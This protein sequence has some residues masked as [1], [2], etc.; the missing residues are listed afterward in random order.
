VREETSAHILCECE[1]LASL[2]HANLGSFFLKPEAI[3]ILVLGAIWKFNEVTG[4]PRFDVAHKG[5]IV[6]AY[7]HRGCEVPN[8]NSN[9]LI[10]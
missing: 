7:V 9:H 4:L 1:A 5:P 6:K 8:P 10:I 2:G 3:L